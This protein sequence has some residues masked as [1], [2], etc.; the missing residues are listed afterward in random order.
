MIPKPKRSDRL[1]SLDGLRAIS[2]ALVMLGHA[3]G[4]RG[5]G[6]FDFGIGDYAHLGVTVFFV[7]SGFLITSMLLAEHAAHGSVSLRLFYARRFLRI[8]PPAYAFL[9]CISVAWAAGFI[10]LQPR[11][12]I[13]GATYTINYDPTR[14]W[15]VGHLWSLS[16]EEQFYLLWPLAFVLLKP[17]H[18]IWG[19]L[20]GVAIGPVARIAARL[21]LHG[22]PYY[23]LPMFP[24]VA[25]SIAVGCLFACSK[26]WL[27]RQHWYRALMSPAGSVALLA[28]TLIIN[29]FAIYTVVWVFGTTLQNL[30]IATLIHRSVYHADGPMGQFLQWRPV[31]FV[32]VLSYSLY[33]WQ[34]PFLNRGSDAWIAGFPQNV[35]LA[36]T[37][38]LASYFLLEKPVM[39]LRKRLRRE[40]LSGAAG[41][42][43][44]A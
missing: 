24:M 15:Y 44:A 34:Q 8:F 9:I 17:R 35:A 11:D 16:V 40:A 21:F 13:Y 19:A 7:I 25:D 32:G 10:H 38:A 5:A 6:R 43:V 37:A 4:T 30:C 18:A 20:T 33:L 29:R 27:E 36:C 23:D 3:G 41:A 2:V 26:G 28:V 12:L 22:T 14:A 1:P 39:G 42:R 31:A